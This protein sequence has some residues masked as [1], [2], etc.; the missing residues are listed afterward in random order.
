[1]EGSSRREVA[2]PVGHCVASARG[3]V[4]GRFAFPA[5]SATVG[6]YQPGPRGIPGS[7][8]HPRS[9]GGACASSRLVDCRPRELLLS[10]RALSSLP[11][12]LA[13]SEEVRVLPLV[14]FACFV[15]L[16][17]SSSDASTPGSSRFL[18]SDGATRRISF[19]PRGFAPPRRFPPHRLCGFVAPRCR[20][21]GSSRFAVPPGRLSAAGSCGPFPATRFLPSKSSPR[22]QPFLHRC[23]RCLPVVCVRPAVPIL[24][25]CPGGLSSEEEGRGIGTSRRPKPPSFLSVRGGRSLRERWPEPPPPD[26]RSHRVRGGTS[27]GPPRW[28][29]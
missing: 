7:P 16:C 24:P 27:R 3:S 2:V 13:A 6:R 17:R 18:R 26:S 23:I 11:E 29:A 4:A 15:P 12:L 19:R 1:L 14:G 8:V 20:S 22:Q 28:S 5:S 9:V 10:F 25:G 21:W